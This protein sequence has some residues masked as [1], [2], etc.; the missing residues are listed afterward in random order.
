MFRRLISNWPEKLLAMSVAIMLTSYVHGQMNPKET[1]TVTA[2]IKQEHLHDGYVSSISRESIPVT[3]SGPKSR[4]DAVVSSTKSGEVA[5][6][7]DLTGLQEGTHDVFLRLSF[8]D[9]LPQDV[10]TESSVN[11][12]SVRIEELTSRTLPVGVKI[13][14]SLPIGW[15]AGAGNI[16]PATAT[17]EGGGSQVDSV[18]RLAVIVDPTPAKPTVDEYVSIKALDKAGEV[19]RGVS[20]R[21]A[22]AHVTLKLIEAP[23]TKSLLVSPNVVGQPQFPYKVTKIIVSPGSVE[24][25]GKADVLAGLGTIATGDVDIAGATGDIVRRVDLHVPAGVEVQGPLT[26]KVTVTIQTGLGS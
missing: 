8:P 2:T 20:I 9:P 6:I 23:A 25:R 5:A 1:A 24:V 3:L 10:V 17:V 19:I 12:V 14:S 7:A 18:E 22:D 4:V 11:R 15:S 26:V 13:S 16:S 21:P